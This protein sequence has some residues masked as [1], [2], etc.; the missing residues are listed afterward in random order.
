MAVADTNMTIWRM[1]AVAGAILGNMH[2]VHA[3]PN[4]TAKFLMNDPVS[5]MDF[6]LYRMEQDLKNICSQDRCDLSVVYDANANRITVDL[7]D[8][9]DDYKTRTAAAAACKVYVRRIRGQLCVD[10]N[11]GRPQTPHGRSCVPDFFRHVQAGFERGSVPKSLDIDIDNM[12]EI[13]GTVK[14]TMQTGKFSTVKCQAPLIGK[15]TLISE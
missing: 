8:L 13:R 14:I 5:V 12:V 6:G 7:S 9:N 10:P 15:D 1:F 4:A 11:L 2:A 3:E